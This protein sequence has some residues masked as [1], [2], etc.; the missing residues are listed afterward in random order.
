MAQFNQETDEQIKRLEEACVY[1]TEADL[2]IYKESP[3]VLEL[4]PGEIIP[5]GYKKCGHCG[6]YKKFYLFNRNR[7]SSNNCTGNCKECQKETSRKSYDKLKGTRDHKEYYAKNREKKLERSR[8]YYQENKEK[9][10]ENQ[11]KYHKTRKGQKV[12]QRSHAKRRY[13]MGKNAGIPYTTEICIDRD[14][15]GGERPICILCGKPIQHDRDIHMEHLIPVVM[16]GKN[17]FTNVGCAHS[18]CN[19]QKSKDAREIT[20]EQVDSLIERSEKY[21]DTHPELFSEFFESQADSE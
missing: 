11:K 3:D 4:K 6:L 21:M 13:L 9:V 10:L 1:L 16:G 5:P 8:Q 2:A 19:L 15:M 17:C 14:K 7:S 18:L 20:T 12:M